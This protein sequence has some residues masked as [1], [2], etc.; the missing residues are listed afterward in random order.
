M[1]LLQKKS[2]KNK[3]I[4][5]TITHFTTK[6]KVTNIKKTCISLP[7]FYFRSYCSPQRRVFRACWRGSHL[8][9]AH[10]QSGDLL[11]VL[12]SL[13]P[14]LGARVQHLPSQK[15]GWVS[16]RI[17][18]IFGFIFPPAFHQRASC[19]LFRNVQYSM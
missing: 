3:M 14:R 8:Q 13:R 11:W 10:R 5:W 2:A 18:L 16:Y 7:Y 6:V 4:C 9:S 1:A 12:L 17:S 15:F 19:F